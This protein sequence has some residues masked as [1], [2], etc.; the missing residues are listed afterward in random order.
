M[1]LSRTFG[2]LVAASFAAAVLTGTALA[3]PNQAPP[4]SGDDRATA[5]DGNV[6]T[7]AKAGLPGTT[8]QPAQVQHSI[9]ETTYI[10]VTGGTGITAVV[11]KGGSAYNTYLAPALGGF[12]WLD[13]HSPLNASGKPAEISHWFACGTPPTTTTTTTPTTETTTTTETTSTTTTTTT[14][15]TTT[16]EPTTTTTTPASST[17]TTTVTTTTAA[18]VVVTEPDDLAST[19]FGSPWLLGLGAVLVAAGAVLLLVLR[20]RKTA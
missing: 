6:T 8:I 7:C 9:T 14:A 12:P 1:R 16:T 4:A 10:D 19:G 20:R 15:G 11:V 13:L 2:A 17:A 3:T 5:H 18:L